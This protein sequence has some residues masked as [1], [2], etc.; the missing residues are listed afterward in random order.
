MVFV[1]YDNE[2]RWVVYPAEFNA[3]VLGEVRRHLTKEGVLK[4][5]VHVDATSAGQFG[6]RKSFVEYLPDEHLY[7][8]QVTPPE[9]V[10][11]EAEDEEDPGSLFDNGS[12]EEE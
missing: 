2:I 11:L 8:F 9:F 4:A 10:W 5:V 12:G 6:S 1:D 7:T 3:E